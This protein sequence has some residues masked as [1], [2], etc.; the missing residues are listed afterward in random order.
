MNVVLAI[1]A[2]LSLAL[3]LWQWIAGRRFPL[4]RRVTDKHFAPPVTLL[5]PL[6]GCDHH[7]EACLRSWFAQDYPRPVQILFGVADPNDPVCQIVK[8][9]LRELPHRDA[10]LVIC[11]ESLGANAKVSK[12]VQLER[13]AENEIIVVSDADVRVPVD[14]L[15]NAVAPLRD[16]KVGLVNCFYQ[17]AN[18][19][20]P[21]LRWEAIA[22][23]A[24]FWSMVL[25]SR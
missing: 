10:Q 21:A 9:L 22:I 24:D 18:P 6:K 3:T 17:L 23:N 12:L 11:P 16:E 25:Q 19:V 15:V 14:F 7:T 20:T 1:L 5:K 4:H 13:L 8:Q 2:V